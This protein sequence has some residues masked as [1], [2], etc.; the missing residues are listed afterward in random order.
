MGQLAVFS[1]AT[2]LYTRILELIFGL[3]HITHFRAQQGLLQFFTGDK[4]TATSFEW[5]GASLCGNGC[6]SKRQAYEVSYRAEKGICIALA[7]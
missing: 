1:T 6:F 2:Q 7:T 4:S 5:Y 3:Y